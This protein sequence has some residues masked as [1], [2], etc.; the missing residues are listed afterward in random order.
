L[1]K[2]RAHQRSRLV[3]IRHGDANSKLFYLR[4]N[5]RKRKKHIQF[6]QTSE[7]PVFMHEDKEKEIARHFEN[8]LGTRHHRAIN[9]NWGELGYPSFNLAN[10]EA[11]IACEEVK[12]VIDNSPKENAPGSNGFIGAFY[13][14]CWDIVKSDITQVIMQLSQLMGNTFNLLNTANILLLPKKDGVEKIGDYRP[15]SLFHNITNI[16]SKILASK[17][18]PRLHEMVS[19]S[20]NIFVKKRCI[21]DNFVFVQGIAKELH[22][23]KISALFLKLDIV[24][25]FDSISWAYLLEVMQNLGFGSKWCD[26]IRLA[27]STYSSRVLLN[28]SRTGR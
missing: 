10:L 19:S 12:N 15:I 28:G 11:P 4:A 22:R 9:L 3:N 6:L 2:I 1:K 20:Q 13:G 18:A 14:K 26:W 8:L 7:G 24:K 16:F 23:K 5:N 25:A 21:H 27:L 17:L